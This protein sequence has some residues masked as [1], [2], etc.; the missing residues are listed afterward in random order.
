M[1]EIFI[2]FNVKDIEGLREETY[3][4]IGKMKEE[5]EGEG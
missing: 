1:L 5:E 2:V 4:I 3:S